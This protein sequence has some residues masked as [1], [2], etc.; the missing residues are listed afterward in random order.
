MD[1]FGELVPPTTDFQ[2]G[3]FRGKQSTKYWVMCQDDLDMMNES[4]LKGKANIL[5]WCDGRSED[6]M[7]SPE[8]TSSRGRKR[9]SPAAEP[10]LSKRQQ[11][12]ENIQD[13]VA[14]LKEKR[15]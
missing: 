2:I 6:S 4:L 13:T 14:E 3:Y 7:D 9:K 15:G 10:V 12:E 8:C 11:L 1:E 5:L